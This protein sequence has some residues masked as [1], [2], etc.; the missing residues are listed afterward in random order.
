[1]K[2]GRPFQGRSRR[3]RRTGRRRATRSLRNKPPNLRASRA[4]ATTSFFAHL[5]APKFPLR[6]LFHKNCEHAFTCTRRR[7]RRRRR[8][9]QA[10]SHLESRHEHV[11]VPLNVPLA[12]ARAAFERTETL[13]FHLAP[14]ISLSSDGFVRRYATSARQGWDWNLKLRTLRREPKL[15]R[16]ARAPTHLN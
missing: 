2:T 13:T 7:R 15:N 5:N 8:R 12:L 4:T 9:R 1:M 16:P 10:A 14:I 3:G 6:S 11:H